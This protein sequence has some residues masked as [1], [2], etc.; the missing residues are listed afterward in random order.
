[1]RVIAKMPD[2]MVV[3]RPRFKADVDTKLRD[4]IFRRGELFQLIILIL[5]TVDLSTVPLLEMGEGLQNLATTTV[6]LPASL[7]A[8]LK[9]MAKKRQSSMNA[10][11]NSAVWA[12]ETEEKKR[13]ELSC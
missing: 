12:Y 1:M 5:K 8:R 6:K 7:H 13:R 11:V 2:K 9:R 10:L 3:F 4:H